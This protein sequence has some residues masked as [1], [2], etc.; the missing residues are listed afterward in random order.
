MTSLTHFL[1]FLALWTVSFADDHGDSPKPVTTTSP[2]HKTTANTTISPEPHKN[3]STTAASKVK[4]SGAG[5]SLDGDMIRRALYVLIGITAIGV[6]YFLVRA[7]RLKKPT[8]QRRKYGLLTNH[9]DTME[10]AHLESD[11]EDNTVYEASSF[12]R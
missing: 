3:I 8:G 5:R 1:L 2:L 6:L 11:E 7:V 12:R 4:P 9:D 10:M